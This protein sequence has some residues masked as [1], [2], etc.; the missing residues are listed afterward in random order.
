[1]ALRDVRKRVRRVLL[2]LILALAT[3]KK[4]KYSNQPKPITHLIQTHPSTQRE[5]QGKKPPS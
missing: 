3:I 2:S 5:K 4:R 1:L